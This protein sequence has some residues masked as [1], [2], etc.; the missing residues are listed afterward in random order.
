M[1]GLNGKEIVR[2]FYERELPKS[3]QSQFRIKK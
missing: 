3:S 1:S 2:T